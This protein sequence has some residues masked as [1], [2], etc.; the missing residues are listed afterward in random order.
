ME[1]TAEWL[2]LAQAARALPKLGGKRIHPSS[3]WRWCRRGVRGHRLAYLKLGGRI[4]VTL[5][6]IQEFAEQLA[7]LDDAPRHGPALSDT[8]KTRTDKQRQRDVTK[9]TAELEAAGI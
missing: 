6:G 8:S 9:A 2:S 4:V 3:L 7:A 5:A 1:N